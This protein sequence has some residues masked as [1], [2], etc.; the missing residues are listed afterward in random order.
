MSGS[1]AS[2]L[3][4]VAA[5]SLE[6][7]VVWS[8]VHQLTANCTPTSIA[9]QSPFYAADMGFRSNVCS[10]GF[11]MSAVALGL[12]VVGI[13]CAITGMSVLPKC[14][15]T[16]PPL[17]VPPF[18]PSFHHDGTRSFQNQLTRNLRATGTEIRNATSASRIA[19][20]QVPPP[21]LLLLVRHVTISFLNRSRCTEDE[22]EPGKCY[23]QLKM[24]AIE[25]S[26]DYSAE[27]VSL[28]PPFFTS[29]P[30]DCPSSSLRCLACSLRFQ[31]WRRFFLP[32]LPF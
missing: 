7:R 8:R 14:R 27:Q 10:L 2:I 26:S 3:T 22:A 32:F 30:P 12:T 25:G 23:K 6:T 9:T 13:I 4:P 21:P 1:E 28:L 15:S 20:T 19:H 11:S 29:L 18:S 16:S 24:R 17:S 31:S 5:G